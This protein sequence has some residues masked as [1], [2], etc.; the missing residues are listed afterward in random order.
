SEN[1]ERL[2]AVIE[3]AFNHGVNPRRGFE[4]ILA[5]YGTCPAISAFEQLA[6]HD[7]AARAACAEQLI[8]RL[9]EDLVGNLRSDIANR[10]QLVPP[11]GAPIAELIRGREWLF[12]DDAYHID[13]SHLA[14]VV[15]FSTVVTDPESIALAVDLTEYGRRLSPRLLF[16]G[17]PP[18]EH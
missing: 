1:D 13:V 4:M 7:T 12:S 17:A 15:R 3:I 6:P 14:A 10:G 5:H 9:H 18:F 2:G 8:R 16:E 11:A